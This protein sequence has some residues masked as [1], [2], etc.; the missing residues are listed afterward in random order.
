M[1]ERDDEEGEQARLK[2]V[3]S[4]NL[5]RTDAEGFLVKQ[6]VLDLL[7]ISHP[8]LISEPRREGDIGLGRAFAFPFRNPESILALPGGRLLVLNDNNY[9]MSTGRN[10][11][12]PD[13]T[14]AII[15]S[16]AVLHNHAATRPTACRVVGT[17]GPTLRVLGALIFLLITAWRITAKLGRLRSGDR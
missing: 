1:I 16:S 7:N 8:G 12:R 5:D 2:K 14:E 4:V 17:G 10:P 13:D 11:E 9:P 6:E 3:Y 15:V